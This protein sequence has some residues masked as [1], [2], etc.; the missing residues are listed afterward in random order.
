MSEL[1]AISLW[2]LRENI[3]FGTVKR[4]ER[5]NGTHPSKFV[6]AFTRK[7]ARYRISTRMLL[8]NTGLDLEQDKVFAVR[9]LNDDD[10]TSYKALWRGQLYNITNVLPDDSKIVTYDLITLRLS[11]KNR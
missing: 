4:I 8:S 6:P 9:H 5:S 3:S 10:F 11:D 2:R 7:V 1:G